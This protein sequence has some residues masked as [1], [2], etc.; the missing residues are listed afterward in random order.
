MRA[1]K[2][3][4]RNIIC[5]IFCGVVEFNFI[6]YCPFKYSQYIEM[7]ENTYIFVL[8]ITFSDNLSKLVKSKNRIGVSGVIHSSS[9]KSPV[10]WPS[11]IQPVPLR[12]M[13]ELC[14]LCSMKNVCLNVTHCI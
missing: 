7:L 8:L 11:V 10:Y 1:E 14:E 4:K 9:T 12:E 13:A 5:I 3:L 2:L 6:D